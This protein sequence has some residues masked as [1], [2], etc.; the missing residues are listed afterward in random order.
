MRTRRRPKGRPRRRPAGHVELQIA[1]GAAA[2][3]LPPVPR[4]RALVRAAAGRGAEVTLR[5]V[6]AAE[7]RAL[8]RRY[9]GRDR[10]TNVLAF[11]YRAAPGTVCGDVV[12]CH[13]V[14]AREAHAQRKTLA[15]HYAHLVVHGALHL[16]GYDHAYAPDAARMERRETRILRGFG[17]PNPYLLR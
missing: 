13:P 1:R 3:G 9:R 16:C 10:A 5:V 7:A 8:N 2:R 11:D 6:G 15:D 4:L 12:L 14:V 17:V